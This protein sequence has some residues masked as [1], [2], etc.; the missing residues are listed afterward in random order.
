MQNKLEY[1]AD[2][3]AQAS[4]FYH[5]GNY[6]KATGYSRKAL[7]YDP[8]NIS[9]LTLMGN[10]CFLQ[11]DYLNAMDFYG[12]IYEL[13]P[14]YILNLLNLAN[15]CFEL[16]DYD[17]CCKFS[18][19]VLTK[20]ENHKMALS[21]LGNSYLAEDRL[22]DSIA[23]FK[24]LLTVDP[25]DIW[26]RN[27]LSQAY[28]KMGSY[29]L[30]FEHAWQA[31]VLSSGEDS[32]Q[33]NLGYLL[34]E[35]ALENGVENI[36]SQVEK[37]RNNYSGNPLVNYMSCALEN[38]PGVQIADSDYL[39]SVF[40][41]FAEGFEN[42]LAGLD[43]QAPQLIEGFLAAIY[44]SQKSPKLRI[45]DAGCG[46]GLCGKF[47][48]KYA[49]WRGLDGVDISSQ[50]LAHAADKKLYARLYC[51]DLMDLLD[52]KP[53]RYDLICAAD[54]FT[55]FG[56]LDSLF[57]ALHKSLCRKGRVIF[58]ATKN[59]VNSN[60]WFLHYSGRF[61]HHHNYL[62]QV[63]ETHGFRI[64]KLQEEILRTE[65]GKPVWGYVVA[66]VKKA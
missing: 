58:T 40:D 26:T 1:S 12:Q 63:L 8:Q 25:Q 30:A 20:E 2:L 39:R 16:K 33:L 4:K 51:Q 66:A 65:G 17:Q 38:D 35:I 44:G 50:M 27:S 9:A 59:D 23:V 37:W 61:Q 28:Q 18:L 3:A 21:L 52:H 5:D 55:Y 11:K 47:L 32:Q 29:D 22:Q 41:N 48:K 60:D 34:Y 46:T 6:A 57:Y 45:L 14:T 19:Q 36:R 31:V 43:Y 56:E 7:K 53:E 64:E 13:D 54:V 49:C 15:A 42:I 24:R 62:C 10:L